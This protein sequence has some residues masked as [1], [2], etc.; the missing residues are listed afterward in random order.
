MMASQTY[1]VR[2]E[3]FGPIIFKFFKNDKNCGNTVILV[4]NYLCSLKITG[5]ILWILAVI[6]LKSVEIYNGANIY[7]ASYDESMISENEVDVE[8]CFLLAQSEKHMMKN[9]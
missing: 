4:L 2:I 7:E 3:M 8:K 9:Q 6:L 5:P 1:N